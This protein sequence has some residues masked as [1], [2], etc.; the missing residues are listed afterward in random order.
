MYGRPM[1]RSTAKT[2]R[3][4]SHGSVIVLIGPMDLWGLS[5]VQ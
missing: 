5:P 2:A 1:L 4:V 3:Y